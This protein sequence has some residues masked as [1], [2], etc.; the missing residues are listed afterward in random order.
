MEIRPLRASEMDAFWE[1]NRDAFHANPAHREGFLRRH[2]PARVIGAF[3]GE[4]LLATSATLPLAQ[5]F[6]GRAV[7]MGGLSAVAVVPD[8]RGERLATRVCRGSLLAMRARGEVIST[9]YPAS[10]RL[11]RELGWEIAGFYAWH[12]LAPS[13]LHALP[14]TERKAVRPATPAD[15]ASLRSCYARVAVSMPGTLARDDAAWNRYTELWQPYTRYVATDE[16]GDV[17]GYLVYEQLD[18]EH[19]TLGGPFRLFVREIVV[20]THDAGLALWRLLGTWSSQVSDLYLIG[21]V[22]DA[23]LLLAPE[24]ELQ[25]LAQTRWMTRLVDAAGAVAMRGYPESVEAEVPITL[26]DGVLPEN[27]GSYV[28]R[29]SKGQ[30]ELARSARVSA[31]APQIGIGGFA[32]L[33]TGFASTARLAR[34]GLLTGGGAAQRA[35]LDAA[36]AGPTPTCWDQF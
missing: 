17:E 33:Y 19:G 23:L 12:K 13:T 27:G 36:F 6:G 21:P 2:D 5:H 20:A 7:P 18:R 14:G 28:L 31:D 24:Q 10:T 16:R 29:V 22:D 26:H 8:R 11:Y 30:G 15:L 3:A 9:L 34:A 4:R 25:F 35:A 1:I 32:S